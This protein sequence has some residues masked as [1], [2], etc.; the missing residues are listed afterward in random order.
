VLFADGGLAVSN[1]PMLAAPHEP[2]LHD[3]RLAVSYAVLFENIDDRQFVIELQHATVTVGRLEQP[4][5]CDVLGRELPAVR[6]DPGARWRID[7]V[8]D[9]DPVAA[10][11]R[12]LGDIDATLT[13]PVSLE[14]RVAPL[15][16]SYRFRPEDAS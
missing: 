2:H 8:I 7:C 1:S 14:G 12:E 10:R 13:I 9:F 3:G 11:L 5:R 6:V 4:A 16:F 15:R